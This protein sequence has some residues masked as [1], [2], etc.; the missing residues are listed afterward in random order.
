LKLLIAV[1]KNKDKFEE[2][3]EALIEI[4]VPGI[5]ILDSVGAMD[6]LKE[7]VPIFAGFRAFFEG[8]LSFSKTIFS[9]IPEELEEAAFREIEK[10][11]GNLNEPDAGIAFTLPVS[12][13]R[14]LRK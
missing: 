10:V 13:V 7:E 11:I 3:L 6:Y 2:L 12:Q 1:I 5:T 9:V 8:S 4:G 14:G